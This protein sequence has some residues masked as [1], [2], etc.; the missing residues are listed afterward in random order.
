MY[1][2]HLFAMVLEMSTDTQIYLHEFIVGGRPPV[3]MVEVPPGYRVVHKNGDRDNNTRENLCYRNELGD[4]LDVQ[5]DA[6]ITEAWRRR[7]N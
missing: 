1:T 4:V 2:V 3:G 6:Q 5:W 7:Q